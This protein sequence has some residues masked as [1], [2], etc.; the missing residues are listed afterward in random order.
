M[1]N[2]QHTPAYE[3]AQIL[4]FVGFVS[5]RGQAGAKSTCATHIGWTGTTLPGTSATSCFAEKKLLEQKVKDVAEAPKQTQD[6][7]TTC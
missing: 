7:K 2:F 1:S 6:A 5:Q 3:I 4:T